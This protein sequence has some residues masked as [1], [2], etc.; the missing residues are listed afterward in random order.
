MNIS[1]ITDKAERRARAAWSLISDPCDPDA[2]A[3]VAD[4]GFVDALEALRDP[5]RAADLAEHSTGRSSAVARW[6]SR[7]SDAQTS[8][9]LRKA[10]HDGVHLVDPL[11]VPGIADLD[12]EVPHLLWV[13]GD[14]QAL[15]AADALAWSGARASSAYGEHVS[16]EIVSELAAGGT[17]VHNGGAYGIDGTAARAA[18]RAGG[19]T[20][21]WTAGGVDRTYPSGHTDLFNRIAAT[22]GCAIVSESPTGTAP[23]RHRFIT[24]GRIVAAATRATVIAEA[25]A[26]SG[27]LNLGAHAHRLGRG[28]G[29]VP[30]PITSAASTGCHILA[31]EYGAQLITCAADARELLSHGTVAPESAAEEVA[32]LV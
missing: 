4:L 31:R 5:R 2:T 3:V 10:E 16:Q 28:L 22:E 6:V 9:V 1:L 32:A 13:R 15:E 26:R 20:V 27:A 23:T 8:A 18:L 17:V 11:S 21:V 14:V 24:R 25:G 12:A 29:V 7:L 19:R 30:G